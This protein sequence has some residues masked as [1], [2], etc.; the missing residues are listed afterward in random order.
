MS[1]LSHQQ[2]KALIE[3]PEPLV[4]GYADLD[5]QLQ[6][7]GFDMTLDAIAAYDAGPGGQIGVTN[8]ERRLPDARELAFDADGY[9]TLSPGPYLVTLNEVVRLPDQV[10]AFGKPRSSLL[11]SGV[12]IHNAVWDAGYQGRSQA[13]MVVYTQL[14]FRVAQGARILQLVFL[15]LDAASAVPYAG[16]Y[17]GEHLPG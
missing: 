17:Q 9:V 5:A 4:S 11:R 2:I 8:A 13:L 3:S 1:V 14:G 15:T 10:M 7:N 12:A 6:A 16:Q